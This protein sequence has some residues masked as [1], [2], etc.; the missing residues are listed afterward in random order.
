MN[1]KQCNI[2]VLSCEMRLHFSYVFLALSQL[3][4]LIEKLISLTHMC[5]S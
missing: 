4:V 3:L 1:S 5:N 2:L